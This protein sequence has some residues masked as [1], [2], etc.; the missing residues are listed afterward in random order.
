MI[1]APAKVGVAAGTRQYNYNKPPCATWDPSTAPVAVMLIDSILVD[2]NQQVELDDIEGLTESIRDHGV[3]EPLIVTPDGRL[4]SGRRRIAAAKQAGLN[5]VP[6]RVRDTVDE[7]AAILIGLAVNVERRAPNPTTLAESYR[8]LVELGST[9][10]DVARMVGQDAA[11]VHQ[12]LALLNLHDDVKMALSDGSISLA[13]ARLLLP[14]EPADQANVLKEIQ[15]SLKRLSVRQVK[16][17]V[18]ARRVMSLVRKT[19][20]QASADNA[21]NGDYASLIESFDANADK[22][23]D[24]SKKSPLDQLNAIITEMVSAAQGE[25]ELRRWARRLS[26][27]LE[28]LR[29]VPAKARTRTDSNAEQVHL[30]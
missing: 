23:A 15:E 1:E 6:V 22:P 13:S 3:I 25:D 29:S 20:R 11:H 26:R 4:L 28:T 12:H 7:R 9:V 5:A 30:L 27:V 21:P 16:A 24:E 17:K 8:A 10:E 18:E 14:L 2:Q 19:Q